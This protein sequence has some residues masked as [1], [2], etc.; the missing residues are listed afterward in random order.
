LDTRPIS[1]VLAI[2]AYQLP[3]A[4]DYAPGLGTAVLGVQPPARDRVEISVEARKAA[5]RANDALHLWGE[6]RYDPP[7]IDDPDFPWEVAHQ[8]WLD[9]ME[10]VFGEHPYAQPGEEAA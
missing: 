7:H 1:A 5:E 8:E 9:L 2:A 4:R 3:V 6:V 10:K